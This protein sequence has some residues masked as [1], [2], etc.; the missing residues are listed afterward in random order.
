MRAWNGAE[1]NDLPAAL[2]A[3]D[4]AAS[5]PL[6]RQYAPETRAFILLRFGRTA[7]AEP[8]ARTAILGAGPRATRLRL[9]LADGFLQAGDRRRAAAMVAGIGTA[10]AE[11][12]ERIRNGRQ[13]GNAVTTA[14]DALGEVL[15]G[16]TSDLA[17]V[18]NNGA[19]P[20]G[21]AQV[22]RYAAPRNSGAAVLLA[23]LL[24]ADDRDDAALAVLRSVPE[25]DPLREQALDAQSRL[26][27]KSGRSVEAL[28]IARSAVEDRGSGVADW[29]RLAEVLRETEKFEEAAAAYA[30]AIALATA[31]GERDE[32]WPLYLLQATSYEQSDRWPEARQALEAGLKIAPDQPLL[33]NFLGY[34]QL[35]RGEDLDGAEAMIRKAVALAPGDASIIDSLGWALYKRGKLPD[36]VATL[37]RAA[38]GD[39]GQAEIQEHLGDALYASG[40]RYEARFAWNAA[41]VNAE[42]DMAARIRAKLVAGL[43]PATAAP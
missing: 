15:L 25:A 23:L 35:E 40:R 39:P 10:G 17:R 43:T 2:A 24:E 16:V 7:E 28:E 22:A 20:L 30:R 31:R 19:P 38:A 33:L 12:A 6:A 4:A 11:G 32:L 5:N 42:E 1:R 34:A 9:A 21:M 18:N 37:E 26:L 29:A 3:L 27:L 8:Q 41:L 14:A 13:T 36:A